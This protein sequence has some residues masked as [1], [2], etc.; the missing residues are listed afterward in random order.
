MFSLPEATAPEPETV[1]FGVSHPRT[2][3]RKPFLVSAWVLRPADGPEAAVRAAASSRHP[4]AFKAEGSVALA[5]GTNISVTLSAEGCRVEPDCQ[6]VFWSGEIANVSFRVTPEAAMA[7]EAIY[8]ACTFT[9]AG[10]RIGHV[11]FEVPIGTDDAPADR[12]TFAN[13]VTVRSAFAS[14]ASKDRRR[15][16]A[17]VQGIEKVGVRVFLD[18]HDLRSND[19]FASLLFQRI[20]SS[21][22]LYLFWSRHAMKSE[23]VDREWRYGLKEKG[24][25]FISPVP[26]VDPRKAAPPAELAGDKHFMDW[27]V[28]YAEYERKLNSWQRFRAWIAGD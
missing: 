2:T 16:I 15:V 18:A 17:R 3:V 27:T 6:V 9:V 4:T 24:A 23:W 12:E 22:I 28:A 20:A 21:D 11:F 8:G 19:P 10:L 1:Q 25:K 5:R 26:L 7:S 14:Y 13:G